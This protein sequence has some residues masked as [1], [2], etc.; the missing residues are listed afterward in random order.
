MSDTNSEK[1]RL[2]ALVKAMIENQETGKPGHEWNLA[3]LEE[4]SDWKDYYSTVES[5]MVSDIFTVHQDELV[6]LAAKMM[7]WSHIRHV[8]VEDGEHRLV[9]LV[10][11]RKLLKFLLG[12]DTSSQVPVSEIMEP[13]PITIRRETPSLEAIKLMEANKISCLP[14]LDDHGR[15]VGIVTDNDFMGVARKLLQQ[16]LSE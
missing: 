13:N 10:T 16:K 6:D 14:I 1:Q 3:Q 4:S 8:P 9:G 11:H 15:L 12:G 2:A 5:F 7:E